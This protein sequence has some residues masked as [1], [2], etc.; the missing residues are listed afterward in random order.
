[1]PALTA[2]LLELVE[3]PPRRARM[4]AAARATARRYQAAAIVP[5]WDALL[6]DLEAV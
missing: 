4:A 3:D 1:V 2:A 6:R 5:H